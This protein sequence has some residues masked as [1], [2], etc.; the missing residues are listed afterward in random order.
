VAVFAR[1]RETPEYDA[2]RRRHT[3]W[4][5]EHAEGV[6]ERLWWSAE[7]LAAHRRRSL[8]DL[9]RVAAQ[10]SPWHGKRLGHLD[11]D[12]LDPDA[13][14]GPF[15]EVPV[16]TKA[17]LMEHWDEIVTDPRLSLDVVETHLESLRSGAYLF[18]RYH[19]VASGGSTG[20]RGVFVYDWDA[21]AI[22]HLAVTRQAFAG[23]LRH[24]PPEGLVIAGVAATHPSHMSNAM[25]RT[26]AY[27]GIE[28]VQLPVTLPLEDIVA[29]LNRVQPH[30]LAGY[31]SA[32][33]GLA[34]AALAG[35]LRIR[36]RR[37]TSF[38]EPLLPEIR[39]AVEEA[40]ACPVE[41]FWGCSE[42]AIAT[43]CGEGEGLHL[44]DD[45]AVVE[46]VDEWGRPV[47]RGKRSARILV[48]NLYNSTLPLIRY[49]VTD[50]VTVL[51]GP[52]PCGS[53]HRRIGEVQGRSDDRFTYG[54][55]TVHPHVFR[56]L[57]GQKR[58]V[59]EY[60]VTQTRAGAAIEV[61]CAGPVDLD[62][63]GREVA[64]ALARLGL[65]DPRVTVT[66]VPGLERTATGKLRR[67]VSLPG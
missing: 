41:N 16:M 27:P 12:S 10:R 19:A 28:V 50:E 24:P 65:P 35:D 1:S 34:A 62:G 45:L 55:V 40:W 61:R 56:S 43:S 53:A 31:P 36:P 58:H 17:D 46:P 49:E 6:A 13:P 8:A 57:L 2:L 25:G 54:G 26:F 51:D 60:R 39:A 15:S 47:P 22:F 23:H 29:G 11:P 18:E 3:A 20:R 9:V 38:A 5:M 52:C 64:A 66:A 59:V 67:F 14:G 30:V 4:A 7:R 48:T 44:C 32:L 63:L 33:H 42:G 37:V 21:W